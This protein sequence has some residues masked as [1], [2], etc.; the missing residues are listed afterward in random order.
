MCLSEVFLPVAA[1]AAAAALEAAAA[2]DA[3]PDAAAAAAEPPEAADAAE[4]PEAAAESAGHTCHNLEVHVQA[5]RNDVASM[6][7]ASGC[8][9]ESWNVSAPNVCISICQHFNQPF[10]ARKYA[11]RPRPWE[12]H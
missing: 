2:A 6:H 1:A 11:D 12:C 8:V 10:C 4:L 7:E 9:K 3:A 5:A